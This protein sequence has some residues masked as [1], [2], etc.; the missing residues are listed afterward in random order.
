MQHPAPLTQT[1]MHFITRGKIGS[2]FSPQEK[3][4]F[5][6]C[7]LRDMPVSRWELFFFQLCWGVKCAIPSWPKSGKKVTHFNFSQLFCRI[8]IKSV[9]MKNVLGGFRVTGIFLAIQECNWGS[10][11][12]FLKPSLTKV[13]GLATF[14]QSCQNVW[15]SP[16]MYKG[17]KKM[18]FHCQRSEQVWVLPWKETTTR[19]MT[20]S[21]I[22]R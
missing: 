22:N 1:A 3:A 15:Q 21:T 2:I 20:T 16:C 14:L 11:K 5:I 6:D 17:E 12:R 8:W 7:G 10:K 4:P 18:W 9:T 13:T 19:L